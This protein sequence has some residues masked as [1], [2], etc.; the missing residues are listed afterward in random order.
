MYAGVVKET[1][2]T[3]EVKLSELKKGKHLVY[4]IRYTNQYHADHSFRL[5]DVIAHPGDEDG[6]V[7]KEGAVLRLEQIRC[8]TDGGSSVQLSGEDE[9]RRSGTIAASGTLHS[10]ESVILTYEVSVSGAAGKNVIRNSCEIEDE[11]GQV[12]SNRVET[13]IKGMAGEARIYKKVNRVS[14]DIG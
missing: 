1:V 9:I 3:K 7:L 11:F 10:G 4:E 12:R 8:D 14:N 13:V 2:D 6:S 5:T